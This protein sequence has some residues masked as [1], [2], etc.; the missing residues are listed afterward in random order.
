MM[1]G[2]AGVAHAADP[3]VGV[4]QAPPDRKGQIGHIQIAPCAKG[5]CGTVIRAF[6]PDGQEVVTPNVG[7]QVMWGMQPKGG[8]NY[9]DGKIYVPARGRV[10]NATMALRG[11][12]LTIRACLGPFCEKEV[13][14]RVR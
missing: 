6:S 2:L 11:A 1:T 12:L 10:F 4:W 3:V 14:H 7:K 8:G 9:G 13:M 5:L